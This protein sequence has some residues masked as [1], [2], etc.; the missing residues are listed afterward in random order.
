VK[1]C[2]LLNLG[3]KKCEAFLESLCLWVKQSF[4]PRLALVIC[5]KDVGQSR[6][7]FG[8]AEKRKIKFGRKPVNVRGLK[9]SAM[10]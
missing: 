2:E 5:P 10:K 8:W 7:I 4:S 3:Y 1:L 6:A 9:K